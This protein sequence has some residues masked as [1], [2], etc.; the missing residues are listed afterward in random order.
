VS[1][2]HT[3][4]DGTTKPFT[5]GL[6]Q[7]DEAQWLEEDENL[8]PYLDEKLSL[9]KALPDRVLVED[10]GTREAQSEVLARVQAHV[11]KHFPA[12]YRRAGNTMHIAG[13]H[14]VQLDDASLSPI[15]TAGLL[16]QEDLVLMRKSAEGWKLAAASLCF[17]SAWNLLEKF[18]RPLH[19]IHKPV[20]GFGAGTRNAGLIERMFDNLDPSRIVLRWNWSLHGDGVL[21]HPHSNSGATPRFGDGDLRGRVIIRLERQTLRKLPISGDILFTIRIHLNPL[22]MLEAR[23]DRAVLATSLEQQLAGLS[24]E[25]A[26]YKGISAE[27]ARLSAR[28][29]DI[30]G[31]A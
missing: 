3:P 1:S 25:E 12:L 24:G 13:R 29:K 19:E 20:P 6:T 27:R 26:D 4:Y 28:L 5:I 10:E 21:Y 8:I 16:V 23:P 17:P 7:L 22:E 15:A 9:Y 14:H 18:K 30:A 2:L 11:L 31:G